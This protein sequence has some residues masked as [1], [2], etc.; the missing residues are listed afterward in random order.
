M[1]DGKLVNSYKIHE[2]VEELN[3]IVLKYCKKFKLPVD[4][5]S[6]FSTVS[7]SDSQFNFEKLCKKGM[8]TLNKGRVLMTYGDIVLPEG[9]S[10]TKFNEFKVFSADTSTCLLAKAWESR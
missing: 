10:K 5:Y 3:R 7:Y 4:C 1:E 8:T 6:P 9:G 2:S